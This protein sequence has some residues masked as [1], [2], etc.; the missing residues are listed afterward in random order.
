MINVKGSRFLHWCHSDFKKAGAASRLEPQK[1]AI[2]SLEKARENLQ[3]KDASN[4]Q[5]IC[6][7]QF[8]LFKRLI[9][10]V[11]FHLLLLDEL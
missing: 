9:L 6:S 5:Q 4:D 11:C 8:S 10:L 1:S 3:I 7:R 2:F